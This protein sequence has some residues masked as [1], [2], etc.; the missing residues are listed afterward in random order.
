MKKIPF[1]FIL[2]LL[3]A[4]MQAQDRTQPK[5]GKPPVVNI[6]KPQTFTLANGLKVLIVE[7]HKLP[8]ATF[9][10][11]IETPPFPE[12]DKKG[13]DDLTSSLM[14]NGG[15]TLSK[16]DFNEEI[17]FLGANINFS[18][19]GAYASTLSKYAGRVL[20]LLSYG[21]LVPNFTQDEL[22]K[23]KAKMLEALKSQE[24]STPAIAARVVNTLA[25]GKNHPAGEFTT[26]ETIQNVTLED[27]VQNYKKHFSPENAYLVIIGDVK[28]DETKKTVETLFANWKK[29]NTAPAKY[30]E[31][32]NVAD[33]QINFVDVPNASQSEISLVNTVHLKMNARDYFA[34]SMATYILGGDYNSYL[35]MNLREKHA[36]TY[37]ANASIGVSKYIDKLKSSA[38]VRITATD[39]AVV[40]FIKEIK[41]IRTEKVSEEL[42]NEVKA[43][44]IGRF[45]MRV[46]KPQTIA[47]YALNIETED[48]PEDFYETYIKKISEVT[49]K[50][51]L[52]A[53]NKYFLIDNTRIIIA[54]KGK[55]AL[56][57]LEKLNIPISYFDKYGNPVEKP[58]Y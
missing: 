49:A 47:R 28:F 4:L 51:I 36:W 7:D 54:G 35:N 53:A 26:P 40:Q 19:H 32:K 15:G 46:E 45:I 23:E 38:S 33:T 48:L 10:L 17:D 8:R 12:K 41:R 29:T 20:E 11:T 30:P 5:P 50:D 14:G 27:V 52:K 2:L 44:F 42:L 24:K 13:V 58:K 31:P 22:D 21:T 9:S 16:D 57:G 56:P 25:F 43:G 3:T 18:S 1:L 39:S 37:G 34:A 6:K 55:E